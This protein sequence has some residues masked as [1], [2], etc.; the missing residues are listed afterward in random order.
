MMIAI[1]EE[2]W[3]V[4]ARMSAPEIAATLRDLAQRVDPRAFRKSSRGPKPHAQSVKEARI[5]G[6]SPRPNYSWPDM[7]K[8]ASP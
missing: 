8:L 3:D 6:M 1:P 7:V 4:F 5:R 2:E